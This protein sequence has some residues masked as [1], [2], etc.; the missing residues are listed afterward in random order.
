MNFDLGPIAI[1]G[2]GGSGTRV[3]AQIL[4]NLGYYLGGT[5]NE[6][7]DNLWFTLLFKRPVWFLTFPSD[8][9]VSNA[10]T[11]FRRAMTAGLSHRISKA[12]EA[13]LWGV[14]AEAQ[15]F[16][17]PIGV[18]SQHAEQ[19]INSVAPGHAKYTGWGWKE[20]NTHVF[21]RNLFL[22]INNLTYI[23]VIRHGLDMAFSANR[24]QAQNWGPHFGI[25]RDRLEDPVPSAMLDYWIAANES[26]IGNGSALLND[27]FFLLNFDALCAEPL[28]IINRLCDFLAADVSREQRLRLAALPRTPQSTGRFR[29]FALAQ[30]TAEQLA[31]VRRFGYTT[32]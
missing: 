31:S 20:P 5:L 13:Y 21:L 24:Q 3:A 23:H 27:R 16:G 25:E 19:L 14:A 6:A 15:R 26:V 2:I 17:S 22:E 9:E 1:G 32:S 29:A 12:E 11:L 18:M 7:L 28:Q 30:F 10:L 8:E 4:S